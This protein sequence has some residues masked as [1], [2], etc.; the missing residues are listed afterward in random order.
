[1]GVAERL[2][3]GFCTDRASDPEARRKAVP[4]RSVGASA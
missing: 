2:T 4:T 1:M 3:L